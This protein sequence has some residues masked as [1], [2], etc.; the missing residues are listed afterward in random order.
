M[1]DANFETDKEDRKSISGGIYTLGGCIVS[2]ISKSQA[3]SA[4]SSTKAEYYAISLGC[5]ELAFVRN[6]MRKLDMIEDLNY[7]VGDNTGALQLVKNRQVNPRTKHIETR[8]HYVCD[9]WENK[10][11]DVRYINLKKNESD[12]C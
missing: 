3:R 8:H 9:L 11:M 10:Q 7:I 2:W 1:V 4:L 6:I 12:I 5:Q